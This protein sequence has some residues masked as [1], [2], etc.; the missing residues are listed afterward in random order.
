[1]EDAPKLTMKMNRNLSTV[2]LIDAD[3][4]QKKQ[5]QVKWYTFAKEK[6]GN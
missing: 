6:L 1:M 3:F 2:S 5:T 4:Q